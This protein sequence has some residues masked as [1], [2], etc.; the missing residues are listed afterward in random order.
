MAANVRLDDLS[1]LTRR[2]CQLR[3]VCV[4]G[5]E[6]VW[7]AG[8]TARYFMLRS[9]NTQLAQLG[10]HLKC[11]R[12]GARPIKVLPTKLLAQDDP[13]PKTPWEWKQLHRGL[14]G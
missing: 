8:R 10:R 11:A 2:E 9:W 1:D 12:C 13:W 5:R 14:R 7:D 6:Q 4:C 3:V